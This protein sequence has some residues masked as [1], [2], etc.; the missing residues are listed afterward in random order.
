MDQLI[1]EINLLG[2]WQTAGRVTLLEPRSHGLK[3]RTKFAYDIEFAVERLESW[4]QDAV[5]LRTP[6]V[7]T[8]EYFP[9]WP[10][11]LL[12]LFPEGAALKYIERLYNLSIHEG[13]Y[14][15]VL[16]KAVISP[17]GNLRIRP[18]EVEWERIKDYQHKGFP[19]NDI[20]DRR[21]DFLE[22]MIHHGAA[23]GGATAAQG[24]APKFLLREDKKGRFHADLAL[25]DKETS[26]CWLVKFPRGTH[27]DDFKI[28]EH[29]PK[30]HRIAR[31]MGLKVAGEPVWQNDCLFVPRFDR[32]LPK[33][34]YY[35][36]ESLTS[37]SGIAD[38]GVPT[39][40]E[41]FLK[42]ILQ[43]SSQPNEDLLEYLRREAINT[44]LGN[45]DNHGRNTALIKEGDQVTL[46]PL[47][48]LAPM[49]FDPSLIMPSTRW[50][51]KP[52][53]LSFLDEEMRDILKRGLKSFVK[54]LKNI[55]GQMHVE[56]VDP[57]YIAKTKN[58]RDQLHDYLLGSI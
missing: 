44:C 49:Q 15:D 31:E 16:E 6:V 23:V 12:D 26:N 8:D 3:A 29:E 21:K 9:G 19:R 17:P 37:A 50:R 28:L 7:I 33:K 11:F 24:G 20:L 47:Y 43:F 14:W 27:S 54:N 10:P 57:M 55:E 34:T 22:H 13:T 42:T 4:G 45:T 51:S 2:R 30:Y 25:S 35:G 48:D 58:Q 38:F 32:D 52:Y 36:L 1:I 40:H 56:L 46:A 41:D 53:D 39:Y 5:S 18:P